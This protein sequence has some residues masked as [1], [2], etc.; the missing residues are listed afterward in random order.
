MKSK[1]SH[2]SL[3]RRVLF[4]FRFSNHLLTV[5]VYNENTLRFTVHA[6]KFMQILLQQIACKFN[7]FLHFSHQTKVFELYIIAPASW[8]RKMRVKKFCKLFVSRPCKIAS[9]QLS[10]TKTSKLKVC[11]FTGSIYSQRATLREVEKMTWNFRNWC[12]LYC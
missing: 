1:K 12:V 4:Y 6:A 10:K 7:I 2:F 9:K 11:K 5:T 3:H 8:D